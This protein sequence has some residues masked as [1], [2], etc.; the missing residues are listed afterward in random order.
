MPGG[1]MAMQDTDY[2]GYVELGY[3][4]R[5]GS[6]AVSILKELSLDKNLKYRFDRINELMKKVSDGLQHVHWGRIDNKE[7]LLFSMETATD[8]LIHL[9]PFF[10]SDGTLRTLGVML[11][12]YQPGQHS[13]IAVEE[14]EL[15]VHPA[16][17]E[18]IFSVLKDAAHERQMIITT[19]SPELI[20]VKDLKDEQIRV[21]T[22]ERGRTYISKVA[23]SSKEV[24]RE[25][26][27]SPGEL[28]RVDELGSERIEGE[29]KSSG[30]DLFGPSTMQR[31]GRP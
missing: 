2:S 23:A 27:S 3:L 28:L 4:A 22:M 9:G 11:A 6:N 29:N 26:L 25:H 8:K 16:I 19:H 13:I 10:M 1:M 20:D 30:L 17:M 12:A 15:T 5:D 7:A 31:A 14:P 18:I 21:V 24:L